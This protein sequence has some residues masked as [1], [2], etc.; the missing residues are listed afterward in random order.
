MWGRS[1]ELHK[2]RY[3]TFI[4]DGDSSAFRS[5]TLAKPYGEDVTITKSDCIGHVHKRMGIPSLENYGRNMRIWQFHFR[6]V[7]QSER[8]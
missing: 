8:V 2:L 1:L 5:V 7:T 4:G 6:Q 3:T